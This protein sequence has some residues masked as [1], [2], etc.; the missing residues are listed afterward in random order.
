MIIDSIRG[1]AASGQDQAAGAAIPHKRLLIVIAW[2]ALSVAALWPVFATSVPPLID[3]PN[4]L[5]RIHILNNIDDDPVLGANYRAEPSVM[6]NLA[7]E[8]I[9]T[10]LA[11]AMGVRGAGRLFVAM[12]MLVLIGGTLFLH[13]VLHGRTGLWPAAVFLILYNHALVWGLVGFLFALGVALF[14]FAGWVALRDRPLRMRLPLFCAAALALFFLHLLG[15]AVYGLLVVVFELKRGL[16]RPRDMRRV[17][18]DWAVA[19]ATF[20]PALVLIAISAGRAPG[21]FMVDY[22]GL[23]LK[24][25]AILAPTLTYMETLDGVLLLFLGGALLFGLLTR[26]IGIYRGMGLALI[27]LAGLVVVIPAWMNGAFGAAWGMDLRLSIALAFVA[28]AT[29]DFRMKSR[30]VALVLGAVGLVLFAAR[31]VTI[32]EAWTGYDRQFTEFREAVS[33]IE[34]GAA[35]FQAQSDKANPD[36]AGGRMPQVYWHM[37]TQAVVTSGAFVPTLFTDPAK[38]PVLASAAREAVDTPYGAPVVTSDLMAWT[39]PA[40]Y[41]QL[42]PIVDKSGMRHYEAMWQDNFDYVVVLHQGSKANPAPAF[43]IPFAAGSFFD[44]YRVESAEPSRSRAQ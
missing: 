29:L 15:L 4:H 26:R 6:P 13:R 9:V 5:A 21:Q 1:A 43:L 32:T 41:R 36:I 7:M 35:I 31:V 17:P 12:T 28:I 19:G 22:G 30:R 39:D 2:V 34:P 10:P 37:V 16:A 33:A 8:I 25:R 20:L 3:L 27:V 38:Q 44:I 11:K 18:R 42:G 40:R 23:G 24:L 14:A